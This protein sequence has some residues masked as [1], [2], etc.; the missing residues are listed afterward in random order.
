MAAHKRRGR[1]T[2]D[3]E[4]PLTRTRSF[5]AKWVYLATEVWLEVAYI[6]RAKDKHGAIH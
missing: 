3:M 4:K 6:N 5:I 2:A 1:E